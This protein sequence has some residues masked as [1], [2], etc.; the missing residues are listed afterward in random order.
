ML[1]MYKVMVQVVRIWSQ[2]WRDKFR[3][4]KLPES[5]MCFMSCDSKGHD[6]V[7]RMAGAVVDQDF[8][9]KVAKTEIIMSIWLTVTHLFSFKM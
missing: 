6:S 4:T 1:P 2:F 9:D 7:A 3:V 5:S 8:L